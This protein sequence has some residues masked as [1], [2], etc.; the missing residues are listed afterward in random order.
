MMSRQKKIIEKKDSLLNEIGARLKDLNFGLALEE[1]W[2]LISMA[3][4]HI[5]ETKPW[6]LA[7]ENKESELKSFLALLVDV[8]REVEKAVAP[9]MPNTAELIR[10]QVGAEKIVKGKPLFPRIEKV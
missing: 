7:K 6:N 10:E 9:F 3:N 5:E 1:I 4:K 2:K 8:I